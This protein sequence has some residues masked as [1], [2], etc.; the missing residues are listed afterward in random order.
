MKSSR[1]DLLI[2]MAELKVTRYKPAPY[3]FYSQTGNIGMNSLEEAVR[4]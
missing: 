2:S 3:L 1:Q 4:F